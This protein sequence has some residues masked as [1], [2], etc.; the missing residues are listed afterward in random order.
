M[1]EAPHDA[2]TM[3][4]EAITMEVSV[5]VKIGCGFGEVGSE[6]LEGGKPNLQERA[7]SF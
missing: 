7:S 5:K 1:E 3:V 4:M 2:K 6:S